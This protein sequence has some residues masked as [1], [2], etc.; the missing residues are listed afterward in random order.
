MEKQSKPLKM[1]KENTML[2]DGTHTSCMHNV[3]NL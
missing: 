2:F 1:Y 3:R